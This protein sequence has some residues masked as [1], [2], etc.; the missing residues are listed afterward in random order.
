VTCRCVCRPA[1]LPECGCLCC[2]YSCQP[3][4]LRSCPPA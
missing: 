3:D 4:K 2:R 1:V